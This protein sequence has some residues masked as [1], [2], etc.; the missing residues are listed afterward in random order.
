MEWKSTQLNSLFAPLNLTPEQYYDERRSDIAA[1]PIKRLMLAILEDALN[2]LG[3]Q[4]ST[5]RGG[6]HRIYLEAEQWLYHEDE[7]ALFSFSTICQTLGIEPSYLRLGLRNWVETRAHSRINHRLGSRLPVARD[8]SMFIAIAGHSRR[9][10]DRV[11]NSRQESSGVPLQ[12]VNGKKLD[13]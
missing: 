7:D 3:K 5:K 1:R 8:G 6:Q 10:S 4:A 9:L 12:D 11:Q 13:D 2:C